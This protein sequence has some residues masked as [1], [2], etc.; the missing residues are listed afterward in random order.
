ML[1]QKKSQKLNL[2]M[3][4]VKFSEPFMNKWTNT[5]ERNAHPNVVYVYCV[6]ILLCK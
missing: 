1:L 3:H 4:L 2:K 6:C 5:D